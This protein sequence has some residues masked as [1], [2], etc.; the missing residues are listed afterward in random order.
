MFGGTGAGAEQASGLE[1]D[2]DPFFAPGQLGRIFLRTDGNGLPIQHQ[3]IAFAVGFQVP[4][5]IGRVK[6]K[7]VGEVFCAGEVVDMYHLQATVMGFESDPQYLS[8]NTTQSI[9]ADSHH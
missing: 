9:D 4:R 8:A 7:Q 6:L 5:V 2:V 3:H 1:Y